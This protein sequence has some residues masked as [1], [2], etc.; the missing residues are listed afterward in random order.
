MTDED[1]KN[2]IISRRP[3]LN[4]IFSILDAKPIKYLSEKHVT[5]LLDNNGFKVA[6]ITELDGFT[7]FCAQ[8]TRIIGN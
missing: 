3:F 8:S 2:G 7:F 5:H 1:E 4:T 6:D